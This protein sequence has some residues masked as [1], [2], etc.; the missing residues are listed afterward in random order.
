MAVSKSAYSLH[1][2]RWADGCGSANCGQA[3]SKVFARGKL[4]C[5]VLFV[6][7]AP[8]D[9]E[10]VLG[11]PFVGPAGLLLD[12][13]IAQGLGDFSLCG[14]CRGAGRGACGETHLSAPSPVRVAF[15]NV[16]CCLPRDENGNKVH[17]SAN[18]DAKLCQPRLAE[19]IRI[20]APAAVVHVGGLAA[21]W[22]PACTPPEVKTF[23]ITHPAAILRSNPAQT[24]LLVSQA[25]IVIE[26]VREYLEGA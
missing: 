13:L 14:S 17:E 5:D 12:K 4:P 3:D 18:R 7:E 24:G 10:N 8:G 9:S 15:T 23:K 25:V 19:I 6:G 2:A 11:R 26:S 22:A 21:K 16:V 20:A 1:V